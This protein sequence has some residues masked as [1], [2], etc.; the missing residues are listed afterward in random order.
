MLDE[1]PISLTEMVFNHANQNQVPDYDSGLR[2]CKNQ[3]VCWKSYRKNDGSY[4]LVYV[5]FMNLKSHMLL[6]GAN[7]EDVE[8]YLEH[9]RKRYPLYDPRSFYKRMGKLNGLDRLT[10]QIA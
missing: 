5:N 2:V 9:V 4:N 1:K 8:R 6:S 10:R 7:K 3:V